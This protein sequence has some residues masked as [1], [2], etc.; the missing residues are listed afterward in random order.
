MGSAKRILIV[1][2]DDSQRQAMRIQLSR[3]GYETSSAADVAQAIPILEKSPQHLVLTDLNLPD[4]S[5]IVLLKK[6]HS[7]YP[8]ATVIIMTAYGTIERA[9]E[10]MKAGAYDFIVKPIYPAELKILVSRAL[11]HQQLA[12]EVQILKG[13]LDRKFGFEQII[14]SSES[15]LRALDIAARVAETDAT[16]LIRG[17]TG[18]GKEMMAK[19]IHLRSARRERPFMTVNCGAIPKELLESE[20]FGHVKGSFTGALNHKKGKVEMAEGGTVL[21]DEIGEMPLELQVRILRLIQEREI[22]KVGATT[23]TKVDVRIIAATHRDLAT[24]A[25]EGGFREDL[26]YRLLVV[27]IEIPPVRDRFGDIPEL[28]Q[29]FFQKCKGKHSRP[30]LRMS[31]NML[32]YFS[33]YHWPGNIREMEHG[34]ERMV[35]LSTGSKLTIDD[36]PEFLRSERNPAKTLM[37]DEHADKMSLVEVEKNLVLDV[38]RQFRGNQTRAARYLDMSRRTLSY[39]LEKYGITNETLKSMRRDSPAHENVQVQRT[40]A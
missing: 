32:P 33:Y 38:L 20:L 2:D 16:V 7:E 31:Q 35:I 18:T 34:I 1:E 6:V 24:M 28:V 30:D 3:E 14:G 22:E 39:R 13:C 40:V 25:K 17:E 5:G 11:D 29:Y 27:P 8:E 19:A 12:E 9:V 23:P 15:L 26:Y 21:L 10:A 36:L 37:F 4:E